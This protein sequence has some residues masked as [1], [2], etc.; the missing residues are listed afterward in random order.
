[1]SKNPLA[2][3]IIPTYNYAG[4]IKEAI[5]SVLNSNFPQDEVEIIVIDDGSTDN[6]G[7]VLSNY[8]DKIKYTYQTNQ[9]KAKATQIGIDQSLGKYIFNL[10]AD[11]YF[12]PDKLQKVVNIF[13]LY[14]EV[15]HVAHPAICWHSEDQQ[16]PE[17]IPENIL[18]QNISGK[19]LL[20]Y[21]YKEKIL[22]GGGSTFSAKASTLKSLNIP[23]SVD[24]YIDEYLLLF[25]LNQGNSFFIREPLSIWRIHKKNFSGNN[26]KSEQDNHKAIRML[27]NMQAVLDSTLNSDLPEEI[28]EIHRL[29]TKIAQIVYEE[30]LN[31]KSFSSVI[32]LWAY[33]IN[34]LN[35]VP[36][37]ETIKK[38]GVINRSLPIPLL[39]LL[40]N[41]LR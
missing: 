15:V 21:F 11:D 28:K 32:D 13:E 31:K 34:N 16:R 24:M 41:V 22:F 29:R 5:D 20:S 8:H 7:E 9:G 35:H 36:K 23:Q 6:T 1:M 25:T 30:S 39:K 33:V 26:K 3:I 19:E 37:W 17:A 18:N 14:S 27:S 12:L 2:S 10:D 38:Y 4:Y 40:K